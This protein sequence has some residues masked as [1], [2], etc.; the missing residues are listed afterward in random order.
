MKLNNV[1]AK[2]NTREGDSS[3]RRTEVKET[4]I[5]YLAGLLD[6]DG[7]VFFN[8]SSNFAYLTIS[9]D[10][11]ESIDKDGKYVA[12]LGEQLGVVPQQYKRDNWSVAN[13]LIVSKKSTINTLVPRLLKYMVIKGKH[14]DRMFSLF[15]EL[16]GK[17]L[18]DEEIQKVKDF[19]KESRKDSGPVKAK[20]W[21]P[22]AYV[23]G[24]LDGD[25]CYCMKK[26]SGQYRVTATSHVNDRQV[27][28]LLLKQYGGYLT[29]Q[30]SVV[31]WH[32]ALGRTNKSFAIP[33]LQ[34][35]VKHSR[36]KKHKIEMFLNHHHSQRLT[37]SKPTG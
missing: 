24:F 3:P 4:D 29:Y 13:K 1:E 17:K 32:R 37:V 36:L 31:R 5:K 22:K 11:A 2:A 8:F 15:K 20:S 23:C 10:A 21:L 35:M 26:S 34:D 6:A 12:W 7:S 28:D 16:N 27:I 18:T 19:T 9:L 33:F 25:G 30:E 14:L